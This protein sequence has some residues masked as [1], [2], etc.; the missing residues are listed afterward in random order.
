MARVS[1]MLQHGGG[2]QRALFIN[3]V[4]LIVL[5]APHTLPLS[6]CPF[7]LRLEPGL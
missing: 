7:A 4:L 2:N 1:H 3:H 6:A 5:W